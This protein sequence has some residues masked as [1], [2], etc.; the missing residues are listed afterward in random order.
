MARILL[1]DNSESSRQLVTQLLGQEHE[2]IA[3][4]SWAKALRYMFHTDLVL[5]EVVLPGLSGDKR[6][7]MILETSGNP[8]QIVLFAAINKS[9]LRQL[10]QEVG[11]GTGYIHKTFDKVLLHAH[12]RKF[13]K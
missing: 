5:L 13:L 8:P 3:V 2:V 11:G 1:I 9:E 10:S 6:A 12:L 7:R 4:E